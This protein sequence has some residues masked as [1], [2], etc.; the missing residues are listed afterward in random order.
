MA[1]TFHMSR[2]ERMNNTLFRAVI[3][4]EVAPGGASLL[5]A[6]GRRS[7]RPRS[8]PVNPIDRNGERWLVHPMAP[9]AG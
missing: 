4:I 6:T 3:R 2:L 5:T 8:T 1:R 7:G 9:S